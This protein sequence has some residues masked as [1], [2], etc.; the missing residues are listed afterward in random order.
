MGWGGARP[1]GTGLP[2]E[3]EYGV[4][5][6]GENEVKRTDNNMLIYSFDRQSEGALPLEAIAV[7]GD[8]GG[9]AFI[10]VGGEL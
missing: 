9:P 4:F 8:S 10:D 1:F 7:D 3:N 5:H 6:V 2:N